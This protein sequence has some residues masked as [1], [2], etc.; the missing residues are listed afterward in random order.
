MIAMIVVL[1]LCY[2]QRISIVPLSY[3]VIMSSR[4]RLLYHCLTSIFLRVYDNDITSKETTNYNYV[5]NTMTNNITTKILYYY[6]E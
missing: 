1:S 3:P 2:Y 5:T 4:I 6:D